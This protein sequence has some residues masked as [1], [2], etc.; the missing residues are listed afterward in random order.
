MAGWMKIQVREV[1]REERGNGYII[2]NVHGTGSGAKPAVP[3]I[4]KPDDLA[5]GVDKLLDGLVEERK[6][7]AKQGWEI[8]YKEESGKIFFKDPVR[9]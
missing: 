1:T 7:V 6:G 3:R 5:P 2:K 9:R 8:L 4:I